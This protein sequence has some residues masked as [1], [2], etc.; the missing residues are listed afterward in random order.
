MPNAECIVYVERGRMAFRMYFLVLELKIA[1]FL[2][3]KPISQKNY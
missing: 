3:S 1:P 2:Y